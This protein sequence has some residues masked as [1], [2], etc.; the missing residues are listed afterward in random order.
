MC[1]VMPEGCSEIVAP[2]KRVQFEA[3]VSVML[4]PIF[5]AI[6]KLKL[7]FGIRHQCMK[8]RSFQAGEEKVNKLLH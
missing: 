2:K 1:L 5:S 3:I 8:N 4:L 6:R 7:E